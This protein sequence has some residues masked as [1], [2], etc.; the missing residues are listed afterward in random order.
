MNQIEF[1]KKRRIKM[2]GMI[3]L[4]L[5]IF[6]EVVGTSCLKASDGFTKV[7][8][9]IG[10]VIGFASAFYF[11]SLALKH[12]PLGTAYAIWSGLGTAL[13]VMV[14]VLVW[15]EK[16][17]LYTIIGILLIICGVILLQLNKQAA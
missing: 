17:G 1:L 5:A 11:M 14:G 2:K 10:V 7:F 8:P 6:S 13:T 4:L 15:K 9:S 3:Y 12:I 16:I